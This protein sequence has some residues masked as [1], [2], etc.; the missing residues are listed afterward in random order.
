[1]T[2]TKKPRPSPEPPGRPGTVPPVAA[3]PPA[4]ETP[5][6]RLAKLVERARQ[7]DRT[8]LPEIKRLLDQNEA[9]WQAHGDVG[10]ALEELLITKLAGRDLLSAQ[11]IRRKVEAMKTELAG[12]E[13]SPLERLLADRIVACWL[14]ATVSDAAEAAGDPTGGPVAKYR[15]ARAE[16]AS[17]RLVAAARALAVVRRLG[18]GV[19]V[20]ITHHA[21]PSAPAAG[22]MSGGGTTEA[23]PVPSPAD[24][25][26]AAFEAEGKL[27]RD[28]AMTQCV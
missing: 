3:S 14:N 10:R 18:A 7:G 21:E 6:D 4:P 8:V 28:V 12:P 25:L 9:Y 26:K 13:C 2:T 20:E 1:M 19:K 23:C 17:R 11:C 22:R 15:L 24:R 16:S 5:E 27:D